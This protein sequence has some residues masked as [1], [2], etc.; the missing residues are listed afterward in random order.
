MLVLTIEWS[1]YVHGTNAIICGIP[2]TFISSLYSYYQPLDVQSQLLSLEFFSDIKSFRSHYDPVFDSASNINEYQEDFLGGK[3][4]RCVR[5]TTLPPSCAVV[6]KS[7]NLNFLEPSGP[8]QSCNGAALP[9]DVQ[10]AYVTDTYAGCSTHYRAELTQCYGKF[11]WW[12]FP[13]KF[14]ST[15]Q[16]I[17]RQRHDITR[18]IQLSTNK[19]YIETVIATVNTA[20]YNIQHSPH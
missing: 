14:H 3:G 2:F 10:P 16:L 19:K 1:Y 18:N 5:L 9:L 4:G 17:H 20:A 8:L 6:M 15:L 7:G 11:L 13:I 12:L